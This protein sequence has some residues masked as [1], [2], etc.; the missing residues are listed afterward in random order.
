MASSLIKNHEILAAFYKAKAGSS[1]AVT[2]S[3]F[4]HDVGIFSTARLLLSHASRAISTLFSTIVRNLDEQTAISLQDFAVLPLHHR[5]KSPTLYDGYLALQCN[6]V[7]QLRGN[8]DGGTSCVLEITDLAIGNGDSISSVI[9]A[10][11]DRAEAELPAL[12]K[13]AVADDSADEEVW[14]T[15][16]NNEDVNGIEPVPTCTDCICLRCHGYDAPETVWSPPQC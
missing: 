4:A 10:S 7:D 15:G 8:S 1:Q 3:L 16:D 9:W 13:P 14:E 2:N 6:A 11:Q 12:T 5:I